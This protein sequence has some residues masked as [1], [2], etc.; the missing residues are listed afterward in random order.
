VIGDGSEWSLLDLSGIEGA[1]RSAVYSVARGPGGRIVLGGIQT[2]RRVPQ[3]CWWVSNDGGE[4]FAFHPAEGSF[5]S[6]SEAGLVA[7]AYGNG[8]FVG[9]GVP[10]ESWVSVDGETWARS[11][12]PA[13]SDPDSGELPV[14]KA[15]RFYDGA[16]WAAGNY[17]RVYRS[18]NGLDWTV[19]SEADENA[20][21]EDF[22]IDGDHLHATGP[23]SLQVWSPDRG[24]TWFSGETDTFG[25]TVLTGGR[26]LAFSRGLFAPTGGE[27]GSGNEVVFDSFP[28][29]R[30][31]SQMAYTEGIWFAH[32]AG[33]DYLGRSSGH[34]LDQAVSE[35]G[36]YY[37]HPWFGW[38]TMRS[39][40]WFFHFNLG[41]IYS[42]SA[43]GDSVWIYAGGLEWI[44]TS[45]S[46]W[47]NFYH[48]PSGHWG[49]YA[50][51]SDWFFNLNT[52]TW[53]E[54]PAF[55]DG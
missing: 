45:S 13:V 40:N 21:L 38:F 20:L 55:G 28:A 19:L 15:I 46:L 49:L 10:G 2:V 25:L 1:D 30:A 12:I 26:G 29:A 33:T 23:E 48:G 35:D 6:R 14:M 53:Q 27:L 4:T 32:I 11:A 37:E 17:G 34:F 43:S 44:L 8:V 39:G 51:F 54:R 22:L 16:F 47:P 41:W 42:E 18:T 24:E 7:L 50:D 31:F 52:G 3:P 36:V 9:A 5:P